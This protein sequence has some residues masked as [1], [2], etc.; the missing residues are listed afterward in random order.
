[1]VEGNFLKFEPSCFPDDPAIAAARV[2]GRRR[3]NP[4][5]TMHDT[6]LL[7]DCC[8]EI[9]E[10]AAYQPAR[11]P[12]R[13][14]GASRGGGMGVDALSLFNRSPMLASVAPLDIVALSVAA[15]LGVS[16]APL[17]RDGRSGR[18]RA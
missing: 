8:E 1:M 3:S 14:Q 13:R 5:S 10:P 18:N 4:E 16:S 17:G 11:R 7:I 9:S 6:P 12:A 2:D 15:C